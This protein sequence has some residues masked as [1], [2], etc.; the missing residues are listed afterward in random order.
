MKYSLLMVTLP[1]CANLFSMEKSPR[2]KKQ[3][4]TEIQILQGISDQTNWQ[5]AQD[6]C[7]FSGTYRQV[8]DHERKKHSIYR[9]HNKKRTA[10]K[11]PEPFVCEFDQCAFSGTFERVADHEETHRPDAPIKPHAALPQEVP[12]E[13]PSSSVQA[14][15][16]FLYAL[17]EEY[18]TQ[19]KKR[20]EA[21]IKEQ[22][23]IATALSLRKCPECHLPFSQIFYL[24]HHLMSK[25]GYEITHTRDE[26][27]RH[28]IK[29]YQS[30]PCEN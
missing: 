18:L 16:H 2:C 27:Y 3:R 24:N 30:T 20:T 17:S 14:Y 6:A 26:A 8:A 9:T 11:N 5:C 13:K 1:F 12:L 25:H 23:A 19:E 28:R 29:R 22:D 10:E 15:Y 21:I 4:R 7:C